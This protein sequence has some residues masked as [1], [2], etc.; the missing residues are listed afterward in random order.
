MWD[1]EECN[2]KIYVESMSKA[3]AL[4]Q[5]LPE[6]K[7]FG[8]VTMTIEVIP[9]NRLTDNINLFKDAFANNPSV[10]FIETIYGLNNPLTFI[11]FEPEVVQYYNDSTGDY[12]GIASTLYQDLANDIF[13]D[14]AGIYFCTDLVE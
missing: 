9:A 12:H 11:V 10:S 13:E 14:R 4:A 3:E 7:T 5:L 2:L 6:E 8:G 1:N